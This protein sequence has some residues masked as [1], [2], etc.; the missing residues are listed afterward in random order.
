MN[1]HIVLVI[2]L[3]LSVAV[4]SGCRGDG[5]RQRIGDVE[6]NARIQ[7]PPDVVVLATYVGNPGAVAIQAHGSAAGLWV[8]HHTVEAYDEALAPVDVAQLHFVAAGAQEP[9]ELALPPGVD[10]ETFATAAYLPTV[11]PQLLAVAVSSP[12]P[13]LYRLAAPGDDWTS[14]PLPAALG[15]VVL[16]APDVVF[17]VVD[18]TTA[19]YLKDREVAPLTPPAQLVSPGDAFYFGPIDES[20]LRV[21]WVP[22]HAEI[23]TGVWDLRSGRTERDGCIDTGVPHAG[24]VSAGGTVEESL[25]IHVEQHVLQGNRTVLA[26][27]SAESVE[28][29]AVVQPVLPTNSPYLAEAVPWYVQRECAIGAS[30]SSWGEFYDPDGTWAWNRCPHAL[31]LDSACACNRT[32]DIK[33]CGCF[34]RRGPPQVQARTGPFSYMMVGEDALDA[35][36][37]V[38]VS[39]FEMDRDI[40]TSNDPTEPTAPYDFATR[41]SWYF[42]SWGISGYPPG[43]DTNEAV[44]LSH[45]STVES[46]AGPVTQQADGTFELDVREPYT[47]T[48]QGCQP[49]D[50]GPPLPTLR[51]EAPPIIASSTPP[52]EVSESGVWG[53]REVSW[54]RGVN[55]DIPED[56]LRATQHPGAPVTI[57]SSDAGTH[58]AI[59]WSEAA[60]ITWARIAD[61][62]AGAYPQHFI[63]QRVLFTDGTVV[64]LDT[65]LPVGS[66]PVGQVG[67]RPE[68]W[69]GMDRSVWDLRG[70][71]QL[72]EL[73]EIGVVDMTEAGWLLAKLLQG[74]LVVDPATSSQTQVYVGSPSRVRHTAISADGRTVLAI[75]Q[76]A[77]ADPSGIYVW[78]STE[79]DML[80]TEATLCE[81]CELA[82]L[83]RESGDVLY[84][85]AAGLSRWDVANGTSHRVVDGAITSLIATHLPQDA[86]GG[87][88]WRDGVEVVRYDWASGGVS[89]HALRGVSAQDRL[90]LVHEHN[91]LRGVSGNRNYF[92]MTEHGITPIS[93]R[94]APARP[95]AGG[96]GWL[97]E[98]N[99]Q[100][101]G[102]LTAEHDLV[103]TFEGVGGAASA[104]G[105]GSD[106]QPSDLFR[107]CV[108]VRT[109]MPDFVVSTHRWACVR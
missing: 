39:S 75:L 34:S 14:E 93:L 104:V 41:P 19:V 72:L 62:T 54:A 3:V 55:V 74:L 9:V 20:A 99:N 33:G 25:F 47:V 100:Q 11:P 102:T 17:G 7:P 108:L 31:Y 65:G 73:A 26:E 109:P 86:W 37:R 63:D 76:A 43:Y 42:P 48:L 83:D 77:G 60:G 45:C 95:L 44:S 27:A 8:F 32:Q 89:R 84:H 78:H 64:D 106:P 18:E 6:R 82:A 40:T 81:G 61:T 49:P 97:P 59:S 69:L 30:L 107:P 57:A 28:Q 92:A 35:R 70:P 29:L 68:L 23:C 101:F 1:R 15:D 24:L 56:S 46:T 85:D 90:D 13:T 105:A 88:W 12:T 51:V 22:T 16:V 2:A 103:Q 36:V 80:F 4:Q 87:V 50:G 94:D 98:L 71:T 67:A 96:R 53:L 10:A 38:V 52:F 58:Y 79:P 91:V 21:F 5:G 66:V